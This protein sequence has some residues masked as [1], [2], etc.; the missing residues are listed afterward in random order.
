MKK[1]NTIPSMYSPNN[2]M[3]YSWATEFICAYFPFDIFI[4]VGPGRAYSEAWLV[5]NIRPECTIL[6]FEPSP[7][8]FDMLRHIFYP[9]KLYNAAIAKNT[10]TMSGFICDSGAKNILPCFVQHAPKDSEDELLQQTKDIDSI[11]IDGLLKGSPPETLAFV[12]ADVEGSELDVL[13]GMHDSALNNRVSGFLL[14]LSM[15]NCEE[16]AVG[17]NW[18]DLFLEAQNLGFSPVVFCN[19]Q[20]THFDCIFAYGHSPSSESDTADFLH[21]VQQLYEEDPSSVPSF[22]IPGL[23]ADEQGFE[24]WDGD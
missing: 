20:P 9:G 8:R 23:S 12:W 1:E 5:R 17:Y 21:S 22:W 10:G 6:G 11:C 19:L 24:N 7:E 14:E 15:P 4:D 18:K 3:N 16:R 13:Q 2:L